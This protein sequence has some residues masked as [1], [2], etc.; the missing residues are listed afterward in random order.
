MD[1][2]LTCV[3]LL[4]NTAAFQEHG[5]FVAN[6]AERMAFKLVDSFLCLTSSVTGVTAQQMRSMVRL[7]IRYLSNTTFITY[8]MH[9]KAIQK[10]NDNSSSFR[11]AL[12]AKSK[13]RA[14]TALG[15][16]HATQPMGAERA[17]P[18]A[19]EASVREDRM[20]EEPEI[21]AELASAILDRVA[22]HVDLEYRAE[23]SASLIPPFKS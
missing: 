6:Y 11:Q 8:A 15:Q 5:A 18:S 14:P 13:S 21:D 1:I 16:S 22:D 3:S 12:Q 9:W 20:G 10:D 2:Q 17:V 7:L 19:A 23:G 4:N